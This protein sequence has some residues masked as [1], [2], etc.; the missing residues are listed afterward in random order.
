MTG[1]NLDATRMAIAQR[2][3]D[4]REYLGLSQ[5]DVA[6]VLGIARP[7]VTRIESGERNVESAELDR[8]ARL[9][10]CSADYLLGHADEKQAKATAFLARSFSGLSED[11]LNEVAKFAE[12]L[13]TSANS[14]S[15]NRTKK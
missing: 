11:D 5:A 2:I 13:R 3:R 12:F 1:S 6:E 10:G 4:S 7:A 8:L 9:F 15:R 14:K